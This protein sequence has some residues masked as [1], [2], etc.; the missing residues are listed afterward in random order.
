MHG[1]KAY[2]ASLPPELQLHILEH[3]ANAHG[4]PTLPRRGI[5]RFASVSKDW[6]E[7]FEETTFKC[8]V[9]RLRDLIPFRQ[10]TQSPRRRGYVRHI[11]LRLVEPDPEDE[12]PAIP[13]NQSRSPFGPA[14]LYLW[15]TLSSWGVQES[16]E[17]LTLEISSHTLAGLST[18]A[19]CMPKDD[20][21][22]YSK[23]LETGNL[24]QYDDIEPFGHTGPLWFTHIGQST[25]M[26]SGAV[27]SLFSYDV[28][29]GR[30]RLPSVQ[31]VTKLLTR[32]A[33]TRNLRPDSL[34]QIIKSLPRLKEIHVERWRLRSEYEERRWLKEH[35]ALRFIVDADEFLNNALGFP[36]L[37]WLSL[38]AEVFRGESRD[39][40]IE[41]E[42]RIKIKTLLLLAA[43]AA[44]RMPKLELMEIWNGRNGQASLFRYKI[45]TGVAEIT[46]KSTYGDVIVDDD[47]VKAWEA[48]ARVHGRSDLRSSVTRLEDG[49]YRYYG[50]LLPHL[51][52]K[53]HFIHE[54]SAAQ[55]K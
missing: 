25:S 39:S 55:M 27:Q 4:S 42:R 19:N 16:R 41:I 18:Y 13:W 28:R 9:L 34:D 35:L 22:H 11:C 54:V 2:W 17:G 10:H 7:F 3:L 20:V 49:H 24:A 21:N 23:H 52:S 38:T 36:K 43:L 15:D 8:F 26:L 31:V 32:R 6:Q 29:L 44:C 53:E 40:D 33:N 14:T 48:T 50:S 46:W 12:D 5:A 30:I 51:E 1:T 47:V 37:K 45:A